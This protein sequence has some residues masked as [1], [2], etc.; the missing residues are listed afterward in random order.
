MAQTLKQRIVETLLAKNLLS[1]KQLDE[2]LKTQKAQGGKLSSI[3][4]SL[5]FVGEK[6]IAYVLSQNLNIPTINLEKF[7][8]DPSLVE[9]I[10]KQIA[11]RYEVLP[12]SKIEKTLTVS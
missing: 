3:L 5:G 8:T 10:P 6:D 4:V 2:A 7:K 9:L 11:Y 1:Q 12:V